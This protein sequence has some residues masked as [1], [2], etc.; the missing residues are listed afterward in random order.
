[1]AISHSELLPHTITDPSGAMSA[2]IREYQH[3][4][5][6]LK[7]F[8]NAYDVWCRRTDSNPHDPA[9][10]RP[11]TLL[12]QAPIQFGLHL[13]CETDAIGFLTLD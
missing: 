1:M 10:T 11:S 9:A 6:D 2:F 12:N 8:D 3:D 5:Y 7:D 4:N 13:V